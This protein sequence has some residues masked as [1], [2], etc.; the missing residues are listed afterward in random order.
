M[1]E[2]KEATLE[3][4]WMKYYFKENHMKILTIIA[5]LAM[6]F[7]LAGCDT[8]AKTGAVAGG[9]GGGVI[10]A[11]VTG[12]TGTL[13]GAA[14]GTAV[15]A[16]AGYGVGTI[17]DKKSKTIPQNCPSSMTPIPPVTMKKLTAVEK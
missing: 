2:W 8:A 11:A 1:S 4:R 6:A 17:V 16:G 14:I 7:I 10:G 13:T 15:G 12:G 9:V 5:A 3:Y